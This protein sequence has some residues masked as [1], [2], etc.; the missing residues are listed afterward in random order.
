MFTPKS[1]LSSVRCCLSDTQVVESWFFSM[2]CPCLRD[3][4]L[5]LEEP[6]REQGRSLRFGYQSHLA[7]L[8]QVSRRDSRSCLGAMSIPLLLQWGCLGCLWLLQCWGGSA[9]PAGAA[10]LCRGAVSLPPSC[11]AVSLQGAVPGDGP[12]PATAQPGLSELT[13][14]LLGHPLHPQPVADGAAPCWAGNLPGAGA[15]DQKDF[16]VVPFWVFPDSLGG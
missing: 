7:L 2:S 1:Q 10:Q 13:G 15:G 16:F 6:G 5:V 8:A 14:T 3:A 4:E 9:S 12:A 11:R